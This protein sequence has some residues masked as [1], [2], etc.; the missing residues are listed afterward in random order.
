MLWLDFFVGTLRGAGFGIW[1]ESEGRSD[2]E[3]LLLLREDAMDWAA[4]PK[5]FAWMSFAVLIAEGGGEGDEE[6]SAAVSL[7]RR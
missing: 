3:L 1:I 2:E 4:V 7:P 6:R 5:T